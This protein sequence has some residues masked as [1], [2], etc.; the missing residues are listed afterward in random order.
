MIPRYQ[1]QESAAAEQGDSPC[2]ELL[3]DALCWRE[4]EQSLAH[5]SPAS[6][7]RTWQPGRGWRT[8]PARSQRCA[9]GKERAAW[10]DAARNAVPSSRRRET[11]SR[12]NS[13]VREQPTRTRTPESS[14]SG[15]LPRAH[16]CDQRTASESARE[17]GLK[18]K[19]AQP[20]GF[21]VYTETT[22]PA[23]AHTPSARSA[24]LPPPAPPRAHS[25]GP[26]TGAAHRPPRRPRR[27]P[28]AGLG[29]PGALGP[30][31]RSCLHSLPSCGAPRSG[32]CQRWFG[33]PGRRAFPP[34]GTCPGLF[35]QS[36]VCE[37]SIYL[38]TT[39]KCRSDSLYSIYELKV[40]VHVTFRR[41]LKGTTEHL[42]E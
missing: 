9:D 20:V 28:G 14:A 37:C 1:S 21:L 40:I 10:E 30:S 42:F 41:E 29:S 2:P 3:R 5:G 8:R 36:R 24:R 31:L 34:E 23:A 12:E 13:P 11:L 38:C 33:W 27:A 39:C 15:C 18:R 19:S 17:E 7:G 26:I 16:K 4:L 25:G 35:V 6:S 22:A 32:V